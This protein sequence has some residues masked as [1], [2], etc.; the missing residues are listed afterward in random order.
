MGSAA[1]LFDI[2]MIVGGDGG[3]FVIACDGHMHPCC[4]IRVLKWSVCVWLS[5]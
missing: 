4:R 3:W 2:Y 5:A 1:F